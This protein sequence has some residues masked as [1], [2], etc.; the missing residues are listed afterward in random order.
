MARLLKCINIVPVLYLKEWY[1]S[2]V[3]SYLPQI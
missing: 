2:T 3:K 1:F